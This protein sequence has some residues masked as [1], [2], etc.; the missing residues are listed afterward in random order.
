MCRASLELDVVPSTSLST[1]SDPC[2]HQLLELHVSAERGHNHGPTIAVVPGVVDVLHAGSEV[3]A[4]PHVHR[5]K[6]FHDVL[7][8]IVELAIAEQKAEAAIGEVGLMIFGN[9]VGDEGNACPVLLAM[10]P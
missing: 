4:A 3:N 8:A 9:C 5:V 10:P 6:G 7:A 2:P 1:A